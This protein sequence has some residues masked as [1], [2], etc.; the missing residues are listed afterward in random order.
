MEKGVK[1]KQRRGV[2]F[3]FLDG[4]REV[5]LRHF[6]LYGKGEKRRTRDALLGGDTNFWEKKEEGKKR[7]VF[8]CKEKK[9]I[10]SSFPGKKGARASFC[11]TEKKVSRRKKRLDGKS[12]KGEGKRGGER[13]VVKKRWGSVT[14]SRRMDLFGSGRGRFLRTRRK[15]EG[16]GETGGFICARRGKGGFV[17]AATVEGGG[18][19]LLRGRGGRGR[20]ESGGGKRVLSSYRGGREK[21]KSIF[22]WK[23]KK[24][25]AEGEGHPWN[26]GKKKWPFRRRRREKKGKSLAEEP[27]ERR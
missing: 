13:G 8:F 14:L 6:V 5:L 15:G 10:C 16:T 21:K 27:D 20:E 22:C 3:G 17:S 11:R 19:P 26:K 12:G 9:R 4:G 18:F 24:G 2:E 7:D 1:G 23:R 25:P